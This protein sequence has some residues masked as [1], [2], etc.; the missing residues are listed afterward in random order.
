MRRPR[1]GGAFPLGLVL[2]AAIAFQLA[3]AARASPYSDVVLAD[4]PHGYWRLGDAAGPAADA[5]GFGS[6]GTYG[7][8]VTLG[9]AGA[10]PADPSTAARF[11]GVNDLVTMGDPVSGALDFGSGDFSVELWVRTAVNGERSLVAKRGSGAGSWL[12]TVTDDTGHVGQIRAGVSDGVAGQ[13]VYSTR[14]IDDG[15]WHHVI[16][17]ADRGS[18]L[19]FYVDGVAAG[20]APSP[21]PGSVSNTG[22]FQLGKISG[23]Q[24]LNGD[25]DEVAVYA[26]ALTPAQVAAHYGAAAPDLPA[27]VTIVSG[28]PDP[29]SATDAILSFFPSEPASLECALDG[30]A[31]LPCVSP[32]GYAGLA[33]GSHVMRVHAVD[34]GGQPGPATSYAWRVDLTPPAAPAITHAPA[35]LSNDPDDTISFSGESGATFLCRLDTADFASCASPFHYTALADGPHAFEVMAVDAAGNSGAAAAAAWTL[36]TVPPL[37]PLLTGSPPSPSTSG[38]AEF[39]F[40]LSDG[41]GFLCRFN[42]SAFAP[43]T[44][45]RTYTGLPDDRHVFDVRTVDEA[46]NGSEPVRFTWTIERGPPRPTIDSAPAGLTSS[47]DSQF[48]FSDA[49]AEVTFECR[50]DAAGFEPCSSPREYA[51]LADGTHEFEVK[52]FS[53]HGWDSPAVTYDWSVDTAGPLPPTVTSGPEETVSSSAATIA[54]SDGSD[55]PPALGGSLPAPLLEAAGQTYYVAPAGSDAN[56]GSEALP[57]R[58]VQRALDRLDPG[59][60]ALVRGGVYEQNLRINH[61]GTAEAP[62]AIEAYP[63]ERPVLRPG[64][65]SP[66]FPIRVT[67]DGAYVRVRGFVIEGATGSTSAGVYVSSPAHHVELSN[68]EIRG[69]EGHGILLDGDTASVHIL[70]NHIHHNGSLIGGA[71]KHGIY[72]QGSDQVAADNVIHD[73]AFGFGIQVFDENHRS[74]VVHNTIVRNGKSGV[75]LGGS[76]GV[77]GIRVIGNILAF[78]SHHGIGHDAINPTAS[79]ADHNV[80]FGNGHGAFDP[81]GTGI[82]FSGGNVLADPRLASL[83]AGD[84]RL[85]AGSAALGAAD[86]A[87]TRAVGARRLGGAPD[88]GALESAVRFDCSLDGG[89]F[90]PCTSPHESTALA[91]GPHRFLVRAL[92]DAGNPSAPTE[93][94]WSVDT[95][96]PDVLLSLTPPDPSNDP[97]A[98]FG[99]GSTEAGSTFECRLDSEGFLPCADPVDY[100]A[101]ADGRHELGVRAT[102][103]AG[104]TGPETTYAWTIDTQAPDPPAIESGPGALMIARSAELAFTSVETGAFACSLDGAPFV[105]CSSPA[106]YESL[107]DGAHV[108]GV[109]VRDPAGN[110][111][112]PATHAWTVDATPPARPAIESGPPAQS[113]STEATVVFGG[114]EPGV[115]YDCRL[116]GAALA[117]CT[118]PQ[119][120]TGLADGAHRFEVVARDAA[121]NTSE[122]EAIDWVVDTVPPGAP[123]IAGPEGVTRW[124][125]AE[126]VFSAEPQ[127]SL[128]CSLDGAPSVDCV[129]PLAYSGLADGP[130]VFRVVARDPA[131]NEGAVAA[132]VW[133]VD[134][135]PPARP[136][137]TS[138]PPALGR[139][140]SATFTFTSDEPASRFVCRLDL[141]AASECLSPA[142]Y[143]GLADGSH[144]FEVEAVDEAGNTSPAA[145]VE[146]AVDTAAPAAPTISSGPPAL[147]ASRDASLAFSGGEAGLS[148]RCSL[149]G[150]AE[151]PCDSPR[152][153]AGLADGV[154]VFEVRAR[155]AAGNESGPA[156][157]TWTVDATPPPPPWITSAPEPVTTSTAARFT[158]DG[159]K[160]ASFLCRLDAAPFAACSSPVDYHALGA[161]LHSF[162]VRARDEAG[163]ESDAATAF[164]AVGGRPPYADV[165]LADAPAGYWRLGDLGQVAA[166]AS[167]FGSQGAYAGGVVLGLPG[168]LLA[169]PDTAAHLDGVNDLIAMGDPASGVLDFGTADYTLELWVRTTVHGERALLSKRSSSGPSWLLTVTDDPG[170]AG[171]VRTLVTAGSVTRQVYSAGR[172]DD[173]AWHH[174]VVV[175]DRDGGISHYVDGVAS[176]FAPAATTIGSVSNTAAFQVGKTSGYGYFSGDLDEV[177]VYATALAPERIRAHFEAGRG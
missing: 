1:A 114:S 60:R 42:G 71:Q 162:A 53:A 140:E 58:T 72:F 130:H 145:S 26:T 86:P 70:G 161:G 126:L 21:P 138:A 33:E 144:V 67:S 149:D 44:S 165:V 10:L 152:A 153:Y 93:V 97:T 128:H 115:A 160:S 154:H 135:T 8:G 150:G 94:E 137:I 112:P 142:D 170:Q 177:A 173:G 104:N 166:D 65:V 108:F 168:S 96:A 147:G 50:L 117:E 68:N 127:A 129:S 122:A 76:V 121:G 6:P 83:S 156:S 45:P 155:D 88:A 103:R 73:H 78:N 143:A 116:D 110:S 13:Q 164:W 40:T 151:Q 48:A 3:P 57:W 100:V 51:G 15:V 2:A 124:R 39:S 125:D 92:D 52:A 139:S 28:P 101:L 75:V 99:L 169:D 19:R 29:T 158:F 84:A 56:P 141:G 136:A 30:G 69:G 113:R 80:I 111:S 34:L 89:G 43:C 17:V 37:P 4:A 98:T 66:S 148:F 118:S 157:R 61:A 74:L 167:G 159:E 24:H 27:T 90:A 77:D 14:A 91:E 12:L 109:V 175:F 38:D 9:V 16:V 82:D 46:G 85:L 174:L 35:A 5:S 131:G 31:F 41:V 81:A 79:Q 172:V 132:H 171:R 133:S 23:Y 55:P 25:L 95:A 63:G 22:P 64:V 119:V 163:N 102:D 20:T 62:M 106:G 120:A 107:A 59:E 11:D 146:W 47:R 18:A 105:D 176:G 123:A 134:A 32:H 36:D 87:Y 54:F 7:G 49:A